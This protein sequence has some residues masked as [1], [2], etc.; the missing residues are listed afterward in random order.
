VE[1]IMT[2]RIAVPLAN[3][4]F[5]A[6]FG[7]A[8]TFALIDVDPDSG[9]ITGRRDLTAPEHTP[10]AFPRWLVE[11]Q[12]TVVLAGGMG[13]RARQVLAARHVEVMTGIE[14]D[15]PESLA[16]AYLDG[17]LVSRKNACDHGTHTCEH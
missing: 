8:D 10:G 14:A 7:Q 5:M 9:T 12:V 13:N 3:A 17:R 11:Q 4:A 1:D 6:H 15:T 16:T 2:T